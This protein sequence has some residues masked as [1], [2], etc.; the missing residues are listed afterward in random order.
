MEKSYKDFIEGEP[1]IGKLYWAL[2]FCYFRIE[3]ENSGAGFMK[4]FG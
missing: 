4:I 1:S 2:G 3:K